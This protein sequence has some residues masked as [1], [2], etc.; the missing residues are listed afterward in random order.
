M[1]KLSWLLVVTAVVCYGGVSEARKK[2][3]PKVDVTG[4]GTV[5]GV[6][7]TTTWSERKY[8][9]FKNIKYAASPERFKVGLTIYLTF[10][11]PNS[12]VFQ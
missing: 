3:L 10:W 12:E 4:Y 5:Q 8:L 2:N 1:V 9:K 7:K 6:I 11:H